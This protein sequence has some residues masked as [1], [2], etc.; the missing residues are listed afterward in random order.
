MTGGNK[1]CEAKNQS[2]AWHQSDTQMLEV[3]AGTICKGNTQIIVPGSDTSK[4]VV[5]TDQTIL[6]QEL[7]EY[8]P[9]AGLT[10]QHFS[11][12]YLEPSGSPVAQRGGCVPSRTIILKLLI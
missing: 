2:C 12:Q 4:K 5:V 6:G 1:R 11:P 10:S 9:I 3:E 8:G 7:M